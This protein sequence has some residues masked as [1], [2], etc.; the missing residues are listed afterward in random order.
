M[1][2]AVLETVSR[3]IG[4]RQVEIR[5]TE[6]L[7]NGRPIKLRGV[8]R[9]E[10]HPFRGRSL[11]PE[12]WKED[13]RLLRDANA[14]NVFTSHY[15]NPEEFFDLCD[16]QGLFVAEEAG[17]VWTQPRHSDN[18]KYVDYFLRPPLDMVEHD[19]SHPSIIFWQLGDEATWGRN[20][21]AAQ[22]LVQRAD[23]TRPINF[24]YDVDTTSFTSTH[25]PKD[26]HPLEIAVKGKKPG[27]YDQYCNVSTFDR[28]ELLADPG[29]R[30]YW[31]TALDPMYDAMYRSGGLAG[32]MIW[33][34]VDEYFHL[35]PS[36][37]DSSKYVG[38]LDP[39][40]G[41]VTVGY[42]DWGLVDVWR[43]PKPEHW[44][45]KKSYSPVRIKDRVL[46]I[47]P[48]GQ[49]FRIAVENRYDF[50][51]LNELRA[52]WNL[53]G[54]ADL[55]VGATSANELSG[56][57]KV[58]VAPRSSG[59]ILI[60]AGATARASRRLVLRFVDAQGNLVDAYAFALGEARR[61]RSD[62]TP[63]ES[64]PPELEQTDKSI[65][66]SGEGFR[67]ILDRKTGLIV[68]GQ[69]GLS[70][71][72]VGGP[73]VGVTLLETGVDVRQIE[74]LPVPLQPRS[75][76]WTPAAIDVSADAST[77]KLELKGR[78]DDSAGTY[79]LRIDGRG[80]MIIDY[81]F[82]YSGDPLQAR[83]VG[84]LFN[85]A[86]DCDILEWERDAQWTYYPD[87]HIGRAAGRAPAFRDARQWP[88]HDFRKR[89]AWPWSLDSTEG[90]TN[91]FRSTKYK[92]FS[93]SLTNGAGHG[94]RI[95][96]NG[97]QHARAWV[98]GDGI[99]LLISDRSNG[100][101]EVILPETNY[102]GDRIRL[103]KG[104]VISGTVRLRLT[105]AGT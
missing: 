31:G 32:G 43:R 18:P 60:D 46:A 97:R 54:S 85:V 41:L 37:H 63:P 103:R 104:D 26:T 77:V 11:T 89:P 16:E 101:N 51:N 2:S 90:G 59:T 12:I 27:V 83:E 20:F 13:V 98:E 58:D 17:F 14:N 29:I 40:T 71:P 94:V 96:S 86:R 35:P 15:P 33:A 52:E 80:N 10:F 5:G 19:R 74:R 56:T 45:T 42:G 34:W 57:A 78:C 9:H 49:P 38:V 39:S 75:W 69:A 102:Y 79:S 7:V 25:Y 4:F 105:N 91:D 87:D 53:V 68:A 28:G 64:R 73:A 44:H 95:E 6:L 88:E 22:R 72:V 82:E 24:S 100:G 47:P 50:T 92:I 70:A 21:A 55:K 93:A 66:V 62:E 76:T 67:W 30:D 23:P 99:K 3:R 36:A 61:A 1:G 48:A 84:L 8:E 65:I 81:R